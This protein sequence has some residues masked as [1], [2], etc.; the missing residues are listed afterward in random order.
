[1]EVIVN[2]ISK[3]VLA[4]LIIAA[5]ARGMWDATKKFVQKH[6]DKFAVLAGIT[7][8]A[9]LGMSLAYYIW[10]KENEVELGRDRA[11]L[12][13]DLSNY[14][15]KQTNTIIF[16]EPSD[17]ELF[18]EITTIA[19][20][21]CLDEK[22]RYKNLVAIID[23]AYGESKTADQFLRLVQS[24]FKQECVLPIPQIHGKLLQ[25]ITS[26]TIPFEDVI[27]TCQKD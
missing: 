22:L 25:K 13:A 15:H 6:E 12:K 20:R 2:T 8:G 18:E 23:R 1:M 7:T 16:A 24:Q 11:L 5:P 4:A 26:N 14:L 17:P 27:I 3:L 21:N 9:I 10:S 19:F